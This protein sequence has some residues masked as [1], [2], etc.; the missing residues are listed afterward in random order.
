MGVHVQGAAEDAQAEQLLAQL[1]RQ[2]LRGLVAVGAKPDRLDPQRP[3]LKVEAAQNQDIAAAL[4]RTVSAV[5]RVV[6]GVTAA[7]GAANGKSKT[8]NKMKWV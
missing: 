7:G 6:K 1:L 5:E 3:G 2:L 8:K 4:A